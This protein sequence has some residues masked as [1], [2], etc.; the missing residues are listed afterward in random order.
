MKPKADIG[1]CLQQAWDLF[2][3]EWQIWVLAALI[4]IPDYSSSPPAAI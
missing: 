1:K 3:V 2:K 4:F